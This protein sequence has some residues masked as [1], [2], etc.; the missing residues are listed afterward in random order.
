MAHRRPVRHA[1]RDDRG[2]PG[3]RADVCARP[4]RR[5]ARPLRGVPARLPGTRELT[6]VRTPCCGRRRLEA[7]A[8]G[9]WRTT[10][11]RAVKRY[12]QLC[13]RSAVNSAERGRAFAYRELAKAAIVGVLG[14]A[15]VD[16]PL[17]F[18]VR[19]A[20]RIS[21]RL[22][23]LRD[24]A[25]LLSTRQLP[26]VMRRLGA[27]EDAHDAH[28]GTAPGRRGGGSRRDRPGRPVLQH[29]PPRG[30]RGRR[31]AGHPAPRA[32]RGAPQ[33]RPPQSGA[34]P[35]PAQTGRHAGAAHRRPGRPGRSVPDSSP[36]HPDAAP[37][38][39]PD[40]PLRRGARPQMAQAR[41][42]RPRVRADPRSTRASWS[43]R[44][45]R[46]AWRRTPSP[47]SSI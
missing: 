25:D 38:G 23:T 18:A 46:W 1:H 24:A 43:R 12:M 33:H 32:V 9:S 10:T 13:T 39:E 2:P 15:A 35:P 5:L 42:G 27:G 16:C 29:R 34:R 8:V 47:M 45:R 6:G 41:T 20:R 11:D 22:E 3:L 21:R 40:H 44:C 14:L 4:P 7:V 28:R 17:W 19:G 26:D 37:R 30:R 36:H 31:Q